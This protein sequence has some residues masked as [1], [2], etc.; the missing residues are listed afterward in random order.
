MMDIALWIFVFIASIFV[1]LKASNYFTNSAEKIGLFLGMPTFIVGVTIVAIGTSL[2]ELSSSIFAVFA[3]SSEMVV[4]NVIGSNIANIFLVLG[5]AAIIGGNI[6]IFHELIRVDLPIL[7]G[8]SLLLT[9]SIWDGVYTL[10][11]AILSLSM[12]VVYL[13][14]TVS[15]HK[16][17]KSVQYFLQRK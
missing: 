7:I 6:K 17:R 13:S 12:M 3:D 15:T 4:G 8:A 9:V 14:Y 10:P 1:L 16:K 11:E 2:P 5:L